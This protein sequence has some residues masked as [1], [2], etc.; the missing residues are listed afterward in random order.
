MHAYIYDIAVILS[1]SV[2]TLGVYGIW[3]M[4]DIY[5]KLHAASKAV[6]LGIVVMALSATVV[7]EEAIIYRAVLVALIVLVTTPISS[8]VI[9]RASY[10]LQER[11]QTP[12][13]VDES[14]AGLTQRPTWRL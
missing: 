9:G 12:G 1:V 8:H 13:A 14:G 10:L 6:F 5:T 7:A 3:K 4:P 2:M 11:M